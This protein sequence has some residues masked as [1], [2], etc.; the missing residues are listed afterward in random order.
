MPLVCK[1]SAATILEHSARFKKHKRK[2]TDFI[3]EAF[4]APG[5][6]RLADGLNNVKIQC[7]AFFEDVIEGN[8]ANF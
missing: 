3:S 4:D 7:F 8:L 5:L 2:L 6:R 1:T